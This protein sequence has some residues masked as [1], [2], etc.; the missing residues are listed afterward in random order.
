M[1]EEYIKIKEILMKYNASDAFAEIEDILDD[2]NYKA[3]QQGIDAES[4]SNAV[5]CD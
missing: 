3:Y 1:Q 4:Y 5:F 2:I